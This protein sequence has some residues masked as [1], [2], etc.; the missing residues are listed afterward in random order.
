[1]ETAC[2]CLCLRR[3]LALLLLLSSAPSCLGQSDSDSDGATDIDSDDSLFEDANFIDVDDL[4][5]G[6][7]QPPINEHAHLTADTTLH[8]LNERQKL[9]ARPSTSSRTCRRDPECPPISEGEGQGKVKG[10]GQ[11][12]TASGKSSRVLGDLFSARPGS[13][14]SRLQAP[15]QVPEPQKSRFLGME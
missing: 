9:A 11:V 1:M 14:S 4:E 13:Q 2:R 8:G 6:S 3:L 7:H 12:R 10:Q 15:A 5:V